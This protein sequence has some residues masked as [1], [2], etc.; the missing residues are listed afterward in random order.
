M[1]PPILRQAF[2]A[3]ALPSASFAAV[4]I[5][6]TDSMQGPSSFADPILEKSISPNAT[7]IQGPAKAAAEAFS[8]GR[9]DEAVKLAEPL[10][11]AGDADALFL[12]GIAH[13]SGQGL[14]PSRDQA[15]GYYRKA[16]AKG[17]KDARYRISLILL[18]SDEPSEREEAR[19]VLEAAAKSDVKVAGRILGE[20]WLRG[21]L[22]EKPN[23][24]QAQHWWKQAANAGDM[25]SILLLAALHEGNFGFPKSV[26]AKEAMRLYGKAA[27]MGNTNAMVTLGSRLLNGK[28]ALRD[29]ALG[30]RWL[31]KA[32]SEGEFSASL[33][34]GDYEENVKKT[35]KLPLLPTN[36]ARTAVKSAA[37][38]EWLIFTFRAKE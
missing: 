13:E 28:E 30:R 17:H 24:K 34:L 7:A 6:G 16:A 11:K 10:A 22:S 33:V 8:A 23:P 38:Y 2:F 19:K 29:E 1:I 27:A 15:L 9:F 3:L 18:A 20:A 25:S 32:V 5:T 26:D 21:R 36:A 4:T 37:C 14:E 12:M 35:T 31:Q